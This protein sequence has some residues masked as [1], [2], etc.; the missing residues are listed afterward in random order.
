MVRRRLQQGF[1]R[2]ERLAVFLAELGDGADVVELTLLCRG[3]WETL[4]SL[5]RGKGAAAM[6]AL[7]SGAE[8]RLLSV[9]PRAF[10]DS[11]VEAATQVLRRGGICR[12]SERVRKGRVHSDVEA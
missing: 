3:H 4:C 1:R 2:R 5:Q 7:G 10:A 11:S 8:E 12:F 9:H 6:S